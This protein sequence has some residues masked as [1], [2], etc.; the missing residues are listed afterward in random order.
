MKICVLGLDCATPESVFDDERLVNLR[1]LMDLGVYGRMQSVFPPGTPCEWDCFSASQD[2]GSLGMHGVRSRMD[3]TYKP[4]VGYRDSTPARTIASVVNQAGGKATILGGRELSGAFDDDAGEDSLKK[5]LAQSGERWS[6]FQ[7]QVSG[8]DWSYLFF[9]DPTLRLIRNSPSY[10]T[11]QDGPEIYS[12]ADHY[13]MLD[14]QIGAILELIDNETVLLVLSTHGVQPLQGTFFVNE[15]LI[16][17]G[18]LVLQ[19]SP[20]QMTPV[21]DLEI[22]WSKTQAWAEGGPCGQIFLNVQKRELQ[23]IIPATEYESYRENLRTQIDHHK[24]DYDAP[25]LQALKPEEV[26]NRVNGIAPDLIVSVGKL[27]WNMSGS[28]GVGALWQKSHVAMG[29]WTPSQH[30]MFVL[31]APNCPLCGG[32]EGARLLDMAPTLLDLAGY[33]IP[34]TMQGRSLLAGEEKK[35]KSDNSSGSDDQQLIRERLAGLGYI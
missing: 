26:C 18:L 9:S 21:H 2:P 6:A 28:V 7:S 8:T 3:R 13:R 35:S 11:D 24:N 15:W 23:G 34:E 12:F 4:P 1:R 29:D 27:D 5:I 17:Q 25:G 22:D 32:Y 30:G 14:E 31:A 16:R 20:S 19:E 33:E 10:R